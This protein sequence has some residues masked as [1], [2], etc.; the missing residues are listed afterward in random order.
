MF[1]LD[2]D[3]LK[4]DLIR[5]VLVVKTQTSFHFSQN[6]FPWPLAVGIVIFF[7]S[8]IPACPT[9]DLFVRWTDRVNGPASI[10]SSRS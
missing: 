9:Y 5:P 10:Q 6:K 7:P 4:I 8:I 2:G 1:F 3:V